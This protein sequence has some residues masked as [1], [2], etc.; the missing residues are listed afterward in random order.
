MSEN[1]SQITADPEVGTVHDADGKDKGLS[2]KSSRDSCS[3]ATTCRYIIGSI[4]FILL[5]VLGILFSEAQ[6]LLEEK[7]LQEEKVKLREAFINRHEELKKNNTVSKWFDLISE[8][9]DP[10]DGSK[11]YEIESPPPPPPPS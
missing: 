6:D 7:K 2:S 10:L 1:R 9:G 5:G 4:P 8:L 3:R 11:E